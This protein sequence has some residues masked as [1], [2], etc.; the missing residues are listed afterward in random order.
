LGVSSAFAWVL[1]YWKNESYKDGKNKWMRSRREPT[2]EEN[3][4]VREN[5]REESKTGLAHDF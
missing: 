2:K 3:R 5:T 4:E 1:N